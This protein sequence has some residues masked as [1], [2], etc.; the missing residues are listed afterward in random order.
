MTVGRTI[1]QTEAKGNYCCKRV[2]NTWDQYFILFLC[3]L[4]GFWGR[5]RPYLEEESGGRGHKNRWLEAA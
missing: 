5:G 4:F 3:L 1:K 2:L